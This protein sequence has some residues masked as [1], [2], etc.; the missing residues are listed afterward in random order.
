MLK[1]YTLKNYL[2]FIIPS[3]I[4]I[5]L[6]I[7]PISVA[8]GT[9]I[10]IAFL[11]GLVEDGLAPYLSLIMMLIIVITAILTL[12]GFATKGKAYAKTP[13]FQGLFTTSLFWTITRVVAAVFAIMVYFE[14]GH[15]MF[16]SGDTYERCW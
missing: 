5:L 3:I 2:L 16:Y 8:D 13:F 11:A 1:E 14:L 7:T 4:G 9:T 15:E 12:L 10:P 6:F